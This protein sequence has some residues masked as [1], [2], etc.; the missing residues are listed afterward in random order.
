MTGIFIIEDGYN[1]SYIDTT[2]MALFY[3]PTHLTEL[4]FQ[5][6]EKTKFVYLQ[7]IINTHIIEQ[8]RRNSSVD[9]S[10]INEIRNYSFVC[11]WKE[12]CNVTELYNAIE[13]LEFLVKGFD[14]CGI[15]CDLMEFS[16][17]THEDIQSIKINYI[18]VQVTENNNIKTLLERWTNDNLKKSVSGTSSY[19]FTEI[20]MLIPIYLNRYID[21][22][23]IN[24]YK[25]D[26]KKKIRFNNK[27]QHDISWVIHSIICF[28]NT[29]NGHYYCIINMDNNE[30]FLFNDNKIPSLVKISITDDDI[31]NKIK[32]ECVVVLYRL[33]DMLCKF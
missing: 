10:L 26:I 17:K 23:Q 21:G 32:Q 18:T 12:G 27:G 2:V 3:R 31:A 29:G 25:I 4:L 28:S 16:K 6:P 1:T 30:W 8:T 5:L 15:K 19:H 13:Y 7:S 24:N 14:F 9:A 22:N 33:D 20:P 11:G